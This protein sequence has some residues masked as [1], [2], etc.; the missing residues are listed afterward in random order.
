MGE[1]QFQTDEDHKNQDR[2]SELAGN[3]K[4]KS[5][6]TRSKLKRLRSLLLST[7]PSS[8][9]LNK[10]LRKLKRDPRWLE[11]NSPLSAKLLLPCKLAYVDSTSAVVIQYSPFIISKQ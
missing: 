2:M 10:S 3:S 11:L 7:W 5:R 9:R 8:A 6:P 1:L 4:T